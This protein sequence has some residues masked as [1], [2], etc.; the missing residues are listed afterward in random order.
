MTQVLAVEN[1]A[2]VR[3]LLTITLA[4][5]SFDVRTAAS[6]EEALALIDR[7]LPQVMV[8][9]HQLPGI[10]GPQLMGLLR[11]DRRTSKIPLI[12]LA[13]SENES[14]RSADVGSYADDYIAKPFSPPALVS[15]IRSVLQRSNPQHG[16]AVLSAAG[17]VLDP[18][19][20]SVTV[21]DIE[22]RLNPP[23]FKILRLLMSQPHRVFTRNQIV[24]LV[25]G[26]HHPIENRTVDVSV[27]RLRNALGSRG[28][29]LI[30]SVRRVGY[31]FAGRNS[32]QES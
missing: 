12:M 5:A 16:G 20:V 4:N 21:D 28:H 22:C 1:E 13:A 15:R 24:N 14:V 18:Y 10:S 9:D 23:E 31:R 27:R 2:A 30:E 7:D 17:V 32:Q 25:W 8:I 19:A 26:E 29:E 3:Q 11:S 6:A